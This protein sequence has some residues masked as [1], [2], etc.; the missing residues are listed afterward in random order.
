MA[1][2]IEAMGLS[3]PS[4]SSIPAE[5]PGKIDECSRVGKTM[6]L[7]LE[8]NIKPRDI[9]TKMSIE[10]AITLTMAL[11]GERSVQAT[12]LTHTI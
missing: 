11:G 6:R 8:K 2:A 1:S 7:L 12:S 3:L 5:D 9:V 4:S 10:N